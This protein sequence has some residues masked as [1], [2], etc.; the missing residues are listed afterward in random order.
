MSVVDFVLQPDQQDVIRVKKA[1]YN[2][3]V[4]FLNGA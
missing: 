1:Q 2:D 3:E 4:K